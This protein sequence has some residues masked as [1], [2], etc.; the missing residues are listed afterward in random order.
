MYNNVRRAYVHNNIIIMCIQ[1]QLQMGQRVAWRYKRINY[2]VVYA[3]VQWSFHP[4]ILFCALHP[5]SKEGRLTKA[6]ALQSRDYKRRTLSPWLVS[7]LVIIFTCILKFLFQAH[8]RESYNNIAEEMGSGSSKPPSVSAEIDVDQVKRLS[9]TQSFDVPEFVVTRRDTTFPI[10]LKTRS[11]LSVQSVTLDY[12]E[13]KQIE[14][15][16]VDTSSKVYATII[17]VRTVD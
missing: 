6:S 13:G 8:E 17:K 1:L 9:N 12:D 5:Q 7:V 15:E 14:L 16:V 11:G 10:T 2:S 3:K 4:F